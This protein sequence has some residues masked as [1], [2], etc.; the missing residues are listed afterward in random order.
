MWIYRDSSMRTQEEKI[1]LLEGLKASNNGE[2]DD[3]ISAAL[4]IS[5]I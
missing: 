1:L 5:S 2:S 3:I 4:K